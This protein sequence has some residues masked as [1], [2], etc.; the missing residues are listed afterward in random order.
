MFGI[1]GMV[2]NFIVTLMPFFFAIA[3]YIYWR[4][5]P[6]SM[7][8]SLR[9]IVLVILMLLAGSF[10]IKGFANKSMGYQSLRNLNTRNV[11][12]VTIGGS[13]WR[14][15]RDVGKIVALLN[16][17]VWHAIN[18]DP[19]GPFEVLHITVRTGETLDLEVG[20]YYEKDGA[21]VH[22][23]AIDAYIP[24]LPS[25]LESIGHMLPPPNQ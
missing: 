19:G 18:H 24:A 22:G 2:L 23:A 7:S 17:P 16:H 5:N 8:G 14:D 12:S 11:V 1:Q 21:I 25:T 9:T 13:T 4:I 6:R 15:P 3:A 20:R 10:L